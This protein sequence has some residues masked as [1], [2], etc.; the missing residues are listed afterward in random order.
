MQKAENE[1]IPMNERYRDNGMPS[2]IKNIG[3]TCYF[4]SLM[5]VM[6]FLPNFTEKI[7]S[8]NTASFESHFQKIRNNP[9]IDQTEKVKMLKSWE[10]VK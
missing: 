3:N 5:Q 7:L 1:P 10:L 4:S 9:D 2:G 8:F 6:F